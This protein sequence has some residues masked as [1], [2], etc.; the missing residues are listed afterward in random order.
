MTR[1]ESLHKLGSSGQS[2]DNK[3]NMLVYS[4]PGVGKTVLWGTGGDRLLFLD[5]DRGTQSAEAMGSKAASISVRNYDELH[6][7][8]DWLKHE[9]LPAGEFDWVAWDSLTLFQDRALIDDILKSAS[10]ANP[11]QDPHV[12]SMRE[13]LVNQNRIGEFIR[14]FVDLPCNFG[15]SALVLPVEDPDGDIV[16]MPDV[17]GKGMSPK[18]C[19]YMNVVGY[20]AKNDK[21]RRRLITSQREHYYGKDRFN[22]LK[23]DG[24]PYVDRPTIKKIEDLVFGEAA[25]SPAKTS[26]SHRRTS[27]KAGPKHG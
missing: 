23:T 25:P 17:R 6:E 1:P 11:R 8:Y 16:Y 9:A 14:L 27:Q 24:K 4:H 26:T 10:D 21:G 20:L 18:V 5:S 15:V 2:V 19:G 3:L 12:A 22:K 7:A 13:Y